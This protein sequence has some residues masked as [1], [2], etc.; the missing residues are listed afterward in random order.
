MKIQRYPLGLLGLMDLKDMGSGPTE[1]SATLAA[2][3]DSTKYYLASKR[4]TDS[5]QATGV[6]APGFFVATG[7]TIPSQAVWQLD[8]IAAVPSAVFG[9]ATTARFTIAIARS[10]LGT[11][12]PIGQL[13]SGTVGDR[14]SAR[15]E[16][17]LLVPGDQLGVWCESFTG[18]GFNVNLFC[19]KAVLNY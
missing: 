3:I 18:V 10:N 1:F 9:A 2:V 15:A 4:G 19:G 12:I 17:V 11:I 7:L 14:P 6:N 8:Y 5:G 16:D 13:A